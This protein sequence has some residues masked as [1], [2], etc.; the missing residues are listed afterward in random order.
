VRNQ[1]GFT[2]IELLTVLAALSMLTLLLLPDL[3][4][5]QK[6]TKAMT[7]VHD[8]QLL[9]SALLRFHTDMGVW[10]AN[11]DNDPVLGLAD[12][13]LMGS[14]CGA[15]G[16]VENP[17]TND[18]G[19]LCQGTTN[20]RFAIGPSTTAGTFV[21]VNATAG[22]LRRWRGPYVNRKV[23]GNPYGGSFILS[24]ENISN[25]P[26]ERFA[27]MI[28]DAQDVVLKLT[29]VPGE[30]QLRIDAQLDDGN[31]S[32]GVVRGDGESILKVVVAQY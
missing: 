13:D 16:S 9:R 8:V 12:V 6:D 11:N 14:N 26:G 20:G 3:A 29:N 23:E 4:A 25:V 27:G 32:T 5:L 28:S 19:L 1:R 31:L 21:T 18:V 30:A 17:N 24:F 7:A 22:V 10:P 2:L 15:E